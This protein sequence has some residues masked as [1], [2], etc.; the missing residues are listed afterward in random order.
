MWTVDTRSGLERMKQL[1]VDNII[2][3][4]AVLARE[5]V[6]GDRVRKGFF[7]LLGL[8]RQ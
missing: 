7:K 4:N 6:Y 3:D 2:T 5:V 8:V 1:G